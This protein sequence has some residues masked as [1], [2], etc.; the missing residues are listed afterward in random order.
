MN[1]DLLDKFKKHGNMLADTC[2]PRWAGQIR[3]CIPIPSRSG[4]VFA[5]YNTAM[6][7]PCNSAEKSPERVQLDVFW[8]SLLGVQFFPENGESLVEYLKR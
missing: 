8:A 5:A 4:A 3:A 6:N 2:P 1:A 7:H